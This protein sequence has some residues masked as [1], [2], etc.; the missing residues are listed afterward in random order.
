[1]QRQAE[2]TVRQAAPLVER[3][4]R[5][6]YAAKGAIY[7]IIGFLAV[8]VAFSAGGETTN[9][10]GALVAVGKE[11]FGQF[12]LGLLAVGLAGYAI[13][14]LVQ[15]GLDTEHHGSDADGAI[16][17]LG[18][19]AN[20]VGYGFLAFIAFQLVTGAVTSG[21]GNAAQDW[22]ARLMAEPFGRWLVALIGLGVIGMGLKQI[23]KSY[24]SNFRE[25]LMLD[26]MSQG[27]Q[28][29]A[30]YAAKWG[31]AARG[32]VFAI[33]GLFLVQAAIHVDPHR[34]VGLGGAL[35]ALTQQP[36]GSWLLGAVA[37]GL[38]AYG[39][40]MLIQARYRRI[41]L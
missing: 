22:T 9:S 29:T 11:P 30:L 40:F 35:E 31:T 38:M 33:V 10:Q 19:V 5:L 13:W 34:V 16:R 14:C 41:T 20:G 3:L 25:K 2:K 23:A 18:Y 21:H 12:L 26:E 39:V 32:V 27:A 7:C 24:R 28:Q 6:G 17:R 37:L 36:Y 8:R 4:A 15:A 1:M